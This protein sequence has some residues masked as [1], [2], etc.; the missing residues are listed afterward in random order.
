[1]WDKSCAKN[2]KELKMALKSWKNARCSKEIYLN[3]R[4][5]WREYC[6]DKEKR[7]KE[8]EE[9]ELRSIKH[10]QDVWKFLNKFKKRRQVKDN[11]IQKSEEPQHFVKLLDESGIK[12][13]EDK[14]NTEEGMY[15][16]KRR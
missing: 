3:K 9:V 4:K 1:M 7:F 5:E 14:R 6:L 11:N 2:K 8:M 16:R 15:E 12:Q 13:L 10:E